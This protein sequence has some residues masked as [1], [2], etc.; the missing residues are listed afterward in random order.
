MGIAID[1]NVLVRFLTHDDEAQYQKAYAVFKKPGLFVTTTVF[2]ETEWVLRWAYKYT[3]S[4]IIQAF[5]MVLG[6]PN[7]EAEAPG[8]LADA[9]RWHETGMDFADAL[10]LAGS[11]QCET[12]YT[13][14]RE[15][16]K[17]GESV[18]AC[19]VKE[20]E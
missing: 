17:K 12:F 8:R 11:Q 18:S 1:T 7:V 13:F 19:E 3:A 4:E 5:R 9:L 15:F 20:P 10:H 14:D 2:L 6:L 16:V